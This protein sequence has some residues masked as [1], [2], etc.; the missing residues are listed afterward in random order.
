[1]KTI[2]LF[3]VTLITL[4]ASATWISFGP[5]GISVNNVC[6][7]IDNQ[8]R[9]A[10]CHD[11]GICLYDNINLTWTNYPSNIPVN[12]A[13]YLDG[14]NILV[15]LGDGTDS[16]GIYKFSPETGQYELIEYLESP[17]VLYYN[18][19]VQKY[20]VG[21]HLGLITSLDGITWTDVPI[22][23]NR[24]IICLDSYENYF[25]CSELDNQY[26]IWRSA[27]YGTTW[28]QTTSAAPMIN[29]LGFDISG[30][31]Y[32]IF[33][34]E[35][36]SSGLWSSVDYGLNWEVEYWSMNMSCV[37]FNAIGE[38]YVGWDENQT[39]NEEGVACYNPELVEL[40]FINEGLSSLVI[41]KIIHNPWMSAITL[42]CCTDE[43]AYVF[44]SPVSIKEQTQ[45]EFSISLS[46]NPNPILETTRIDYNLMDQG[47]F[48]S[49]TI[50]NTEGK[51]IK[52]YSLDQVSGNLILNCSDLR[53]GLYYIMLKTGD[54]SITKKMIKTTNR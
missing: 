33:P 39:G 13:Y 24:N 12:G 7:V 3:L 11:E 45:R 21:H 27:D 19:D 49:L 43:G 25:V 22:F 2:I 29:Q 8:N 15:I 40:S 54:I 32:G 10:I 14:N 1:M 6:F 5:V 4:N 51:Y 26:S 30:K 38:V 31:L 52:N 34:D 23:N 17:N 20:F 18:E 28:T 42:F 16:D 44:N 9:W 41:N 50:F 48:A 36:D 37:G 47:T 46:I 35:L 53:P